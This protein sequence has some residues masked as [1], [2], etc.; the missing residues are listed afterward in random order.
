MDSTTTQK[1]AFDMLKQMNIPVVQQNL[2]HYAG[3]GANINTLQLLLK[4]GLDPNQTYTTEKG[5]VY[6]ILHSAITWGTIKTVEI[7]L[8]NGADINLQNASTKETALIIASRL[9]KSD[10]VKLL[11]DKGANLNI[12]TNDNANALFVAQKNKNGEI[13]EL[14]KKAGA[15]E[16][17]SQ[18]IDIYK[19]KRKRKLIMSLSIL[20]V[21]IAGFST[22]TYWFA[23]NGSSS[24]SSSSSST[25]THTCE[26]CHK[27]YT[28]VGYS[29]IEDQC[30]SSN[31]DY[32]QC[33]SQKCCMEEWN[34]SH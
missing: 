33:C 4:A 24:S 31:K 28:G 13:V 32:D 10:I 25:K 12:K 34:A 8:D 7:L 11:I 15:Q 5:V 18:D 27:Q 17:S 21:C 22:C 19:K 6:Y 1:E 26:W 2:N 23:N 9:G 29:H 16:L 30:F 14:L 3:G 20:A